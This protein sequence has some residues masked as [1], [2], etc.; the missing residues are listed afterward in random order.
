MKTKTNFLLLLITSFTASASMAQVNTAVQQTVTASKAVAATA[1]LGATKAAAN[2]A[3]QATINA[4][5]RAAVNGTKAIGVTA[6]KAAEQLM[7]PCIP[8]GRLQWRLGGSYRPRLHTG[9]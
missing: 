2:A 5:A 1:T 9:L 4:S 3:T 6:A 7:S 8:M